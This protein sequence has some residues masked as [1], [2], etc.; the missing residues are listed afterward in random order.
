MLRLAARWQRFAKNGNRI[1]PGP[2]SRLQSSHA[3]DYFLG[4]KIKALL[5]AHPSP[6]PPTDSPIN[7]LRLPISHSPTPATHSLAPSNHPITGPP[8]YQPT[9]PSNIS[10]AHITTHSLPPATHSLTHHPLTLQPN[11]QLAR[12]LNHPSLFSVSPL[13]T[14]F[15][16]L[17]VFCLP[18]L[19][20]HFSFLFLIIH[21]S[22]LSFFLTS[23]S[24]LFLPHSISFNYFL[25]PLSPIFSSFLRLHSS[26][27]LLQYLPP[28]PFFFLSI[29]YFPLF[30]S[31][32]PLFFAIIPHSIIFFLFFLLHFL[33]RFSFTLI[34]SFLYLQFSSSIPPVGVPSLS[35]DEY[36]ASA[37]INRTLFSFNSLSSQN[38]AGQFRA[39]DHIID[40]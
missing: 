14:F 39:T 2:R 32:L 4:L 8:N 26:S 34:F 1:R 38:T 10:V 15:P 5:T 35:A 6:T 24:V 21:Q 30:S 40:F 29:L 31:L 9:R 19:L 12:S 33:S 27:F 37:D 22:L 16:L 11:L 13:A 7:P 17:L 23:P 25:I 28:P 18:S 3:R 36:K 20:P